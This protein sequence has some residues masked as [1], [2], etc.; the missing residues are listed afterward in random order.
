MYCSA[1]SCTI[2]W[3]VVASLAQQAARQSHNLKVVSS[4]LTGSSIFFLHHLHVRAFCFAKQYVCMQQKL[5]YELY[6]VTMTSLFS[7]V[8]NGLIP[9]N[10]Q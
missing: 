9:F 5:Q 4:I 7:F 1:V 6:P 3:Y 8:S 10:D 2:D